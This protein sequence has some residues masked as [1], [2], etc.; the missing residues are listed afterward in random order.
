MMNPERW[1]ELE[2]TF[3]KDEDFDKDGYYV[4]NNG[5]PE[6]DV[7]DWLEC[8][9]TSPSW[10]MMDIFRNHG[11]DVY[12]GEKDSFGWLI[13]IVEEKKSGRRIVFG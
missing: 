12:P 7:M 2:E 8:S 13:G 9:T 1:K 5:Y 6:F 11:Y 3:K 4:A 10:R